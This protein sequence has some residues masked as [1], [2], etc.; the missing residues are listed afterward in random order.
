MPRR[1]RMSIM[2]GERDKQERTIE[3]VRNVAHECGYAVG[4][5]G[6]RE[7]DLDLIAAPWVAEADTFDQLVAAFQAAGFLVGAQT[8]QQ[9]CPHGRRGIVLHG[10]AGCKYVDLSV[11]PLAPGQRRDLD[12]AALQRAAAHALMGPCRVCGDRGTRQ[13]RGGDEYLCERHLP[14]RTMKS[15]ARP[16]GSDGAFKA[17]G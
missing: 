12:D 14:P 15:P 1:T 11:M 9:A 13:M 16:W 2:S 6:S 17:A 10:V 3:R 4:V 7:R 8:E 5:H